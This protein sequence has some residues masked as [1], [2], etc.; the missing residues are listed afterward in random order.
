[1]STDASD[2]IR[3]RLSAVLARLG[4][5]AYSVGPVDAEALV[6]ALSVAEHELGIVMSLAKRLP[7][8]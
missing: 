8:P 4:P 7:N 2:E 6:A 3:S 1:M 5:I